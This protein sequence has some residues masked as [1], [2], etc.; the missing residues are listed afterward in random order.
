MKA[1]Q[2]SRYHVLAYIFGVSESFRWQAAEK[3]ENLNFRSERNNLFLGK[4][5]GRISCGVEGKRDGKRSFN[6]SPG[7]CELMEV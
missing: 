2:K 5:R 7:I 1:A 3:D 6:L 4:K